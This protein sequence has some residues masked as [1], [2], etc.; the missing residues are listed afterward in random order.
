LAD[1]VRAPIGPKKE[2]T[3]VI[4]ED[5]R[6]KGSSLLHLR[7][8]MNACSTRAVTRCYEHVFKSLLEALIVATY[9][10]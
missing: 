10:I 5:K 4:D 3:E 8:E 2:K 7:R 1:N 9:D 6:A